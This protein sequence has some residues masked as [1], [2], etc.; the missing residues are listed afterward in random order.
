MDIVEQALLLPG[1]CYVTGR[2]EGPF[3]DTGYMIDDLADV[4]RVYL[5]VSF[6]SDAIGQVGGLGPE[7]AAVLRDRNAELA[8]ENARL[9]SAVEGLVDANEALVKA[10]YP[11]AATEPAVEP[12]PG[13][14]S[15]SDD[16][17]LDAVLARP[18]LD[19]PDDASRA[20]MIDA[21]EAAK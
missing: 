16:Q 14:E 15:Y 4:G 19:L 12:E 17:L 13:F 6:L 3:L 8:R 21:L 2:S 1:A 18:D 9:A 10:G 7:A 20:Q 11:V 5:S